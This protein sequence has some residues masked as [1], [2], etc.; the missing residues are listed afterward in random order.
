MDEG[1]YLFYLAGLFLRN[2]IERFNPNK[3]DINSDP[4][5][6][7][8]YSLPQDYW[9]ELSLKEIGSHL[10]EFI[11]IVEETKLNRYIAYARIYVYMHLVKALPYLVSLFHD[12]FEWVQSIDCEH[13][14]FHCR[15]CHEHEHIFRD[16]PLN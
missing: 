12:D 10:G 14:P 16:C 2:W 4:I 1:P 13:V 9:D 5:W 7:K 3:E 11:K 8:L 15:K 6:I